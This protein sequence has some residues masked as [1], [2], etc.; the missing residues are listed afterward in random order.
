M[1]RWALLA[2]WAWCALAQAEAVGFAFRGV[3]VTEF[4]ETV[5]RGVLARDYV[6]APDVA[7]SPERITMAVKA[8][9]KDQALELAR[10]VLAGLGVSVRER[11]G[12]LYIEKAV[13]A[14]LP[15]VLAMPQ[16]G[17]PAPVPANG[18]APAPP[19][20]VR[21]YWPKARNVAFLGELVRLA[22]GR[23]PE[24]AAGGDVLMY[25][26]AEEVVERIERLLLEVDRSV[27][28]VT[29][30]AA[31]VEFS[32]ASDTARSF[33]AVL[34]L[35]GGR[36][37]LTYQAGAALADAVTFKSATLQAVLSAIDG[38]SRFRYLAEP[39]VRVLDG[40]SARLVVGAEVP[41]RGSVT[42]DQAGNALQSVEYR[43]AG[44]VINL[45]P[46]I[47]GERVELKVAQ[48][49]SNFATTT[50][51]NIDSPTL[52][53]RQSETTVQVMPGELVV[54]AG[55]DETRESESH[56]GL[57]FLPR[58]LGSKASSRSRSQVLLLLE[59]I[60]DGAASG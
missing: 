19:E 40:Q 13:A 59:V 17:A 16:E 27:A 10:G 23:V 26:G 53:K 3:A 1:S 32:E 5:F 58:W 39:M 46:K 11:A 29:V 8:V 44:V 15:P 55:M 7:A 18:A 2:L 36:L 20:A 30:R 45:A 42:L 52:F 33:S 50:T 51:S 48:E 21:L 43:T 57:A 54:L 12:V 14:E 9:E 47:L 49:V 35:L 56:S 28:S 4:V 31:L 25:S 38:D 41:V 6:L 22:G 34:S 37:G 24:K 60:R